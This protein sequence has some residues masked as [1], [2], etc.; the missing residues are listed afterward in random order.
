MTLNCPICA[1]ALNQRS[2]NGETVDCCNTCHG[3]WYDSAELSSSLRR[4]KTGIE[5]LHTSTESPKT[6]S[7]PKCITE[8]SSTIYAHDSGIPILKCPTCSG[9]WLAAGQLE[10]IIEYRNATH[11]TDGLAQA[12]AESFAQSNGGFARL[13]HSRLLSTLFALV[14]LIVAASLGAGIAG[15]LGLV[16][17]LLLPMACIWFSDAMG[18]L[19]GIRMGLVRPTITSPTPGIAIALGGWILMFVRFAVMIYEMTGR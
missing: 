11:K 13:I 3:T 7:C 12:T 14:I 1:V 8:I 6:I 17:F 16:V 15:I 9:I 5:S 19:T 18:N 4:T 10:K 2:L